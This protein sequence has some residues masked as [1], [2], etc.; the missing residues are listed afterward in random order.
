MK[1]Q[2][3]DN[4]IEINTEI[5][6]GKPVIR[7]TR[8]SVQFILKLLAQGVSISQIMSEYNKLTKDDILACIMYA[9]ETIDSNMFYP[10]NSSTD[11]VYS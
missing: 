6:A 4:R 1:T 11:E 10:I 5:L 8:L 7:G 2:L 3:F 9:A